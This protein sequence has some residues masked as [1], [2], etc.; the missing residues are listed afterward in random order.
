MKLLDA[1]RVPDPARVREEMVALPERERRAL[2]EDD[3]KREYLGIPLGGQASPFTWDLYERATQ[4][5]VPLVPPG[6]AFGPP[7]QERAVPVPNPF[8]GLRPIGG[9]P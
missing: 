5:H 7:V 9:L 3:F 4:V 1:L 2:G 8:H 6:P